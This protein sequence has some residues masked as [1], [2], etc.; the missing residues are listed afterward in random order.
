VNPAI[1]LIYFAFY[2]GL[3]PDYPLK[4]FRHFRPEFG[5]ERN[6][7]NPFCIDSRGMRY[8]VRPIT[9]LEILDHHRRR[10]NQDR[11]FGLLVGKRRR[12]MIEVTGAINILVSINEEEQTFDIQQSEML[13]MI[14]LHK[15]SCPE[16]HWVGMYATHHA[17]DYWFAKVHE[18]V[19]NKMKALNLSFVDNA[20]FLTVGVGNTEN[21]IRATGYTFKNK[22]GQSSKFGI[23]RYVG[24][25][26]KLQG[27]PNENLSI[28][29]LMNSPEKKEAEET[30][31]SVEEFN[32]TNERSTLRSSSE[33]VAE[34]MHKIAE[35]L[36]EFKEY[37]EDE[38]RR[39]PELG[40]D[41][42]AALSEVPCIP[43]NEF[44]SMISGSIQDL[45][46]TD[47]L[48]KLVKVHVNLAGK[49]NGF[50]PRQ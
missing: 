43:E 6:M 15:R 33:V 26:V 50:Q 10:R 14:Q 7:N 35:A 12:R 21:R 31:V 4:P 1:F 25:P 44:Q 49:L 23:C 48:A 5:K 46:M 40:W 28:W 42:A 36:A 45:L 13:K 19:D 41:L 18:Q 29:T 17:P 16:D 32:F 38:S 11:V 27:T 30:P 3:N 22:F 24:V 47:V 37:V 20:L 39:D 2:K 34:Q 8:Q 9:L